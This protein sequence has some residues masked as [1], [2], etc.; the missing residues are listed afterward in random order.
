MKS[1]II[2]NVLVL[3]LKFYAVIAFNKTAQKSSYMFKSAQKNIFS[4]QS[5][6]LI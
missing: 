2:P 4:Y 3:K 6:F 5:R 1:Q